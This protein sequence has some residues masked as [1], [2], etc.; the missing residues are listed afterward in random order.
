MIDLAQARTSSSAEMPGPTALQAL[1]ALTYA[2]TQLEFLL[3]RSQAIDVDAGNLYEWQELARQLLE[4]RD[5][6]LL[7]ITRPL[8]PHSS[9]TMVAR[10]GSHVTADPEY[11]E[12]LAHR[13]ATH[14]R[15]VDFSDLLPAAGWRE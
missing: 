6:V 7:A 5:R 4:D 2:S 12:Q 3:D 10:D 8:L 15:L 13:T 14:A 11:I 1:G 9:M